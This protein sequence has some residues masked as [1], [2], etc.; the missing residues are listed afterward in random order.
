LKKNK[1]NNFTS[2]LQFIKKTFKGEKVEINSAE[3]FAKIVA[4]F[5]T[6]REFVDKTFV[7]T[8]Q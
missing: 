2:F 8:S 1:G 7:L 6:D 3:D 4:C 5:R